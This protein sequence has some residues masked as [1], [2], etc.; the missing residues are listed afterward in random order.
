MTNDVQNKPQP[1]QSRLV[2]IAGRGCIDAVTM[3]LVGA[4][5]MSWQ[6]AHTAPG[7]PAHTALADFLYANRGLLAD[8]SAVDVLVDTPRM[9]VVPPGMSDRQIAEDFAALYPA[10]DLDIFADPVFATGQ[11][12]R[13]AMAVDPALPGFLRRTYA[14]PR[15]MHRLTPPVRFFGLKSRLGNS[16]KLHVHLRN[17]STSVIA[18]GANG[19]LL[20]A[21][22]FVTKSHVDAL[23]YAL[24]AAQRFEYD[25]DAD[26]T[27][28]SGDTALR[29][30]LMPLL[31][32]YIPAAMPAIF[33]A[34]LFKSGPAAMQAP[35][36]ATVLQMLS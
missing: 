1:A 16:G 4:A 22:T 34:A 33:P 30:K 19:T 36:E 13:M 14:N 11:S 6:Q 25:H 20:M 23:Y 3:P 17:G 18:F 26:R 29:Q 21:N 28:V 10:E 15:I 2:L 31:R 7:T 9:T 5:H 32:R 27:F 35:F 24:A 12:P 8:F